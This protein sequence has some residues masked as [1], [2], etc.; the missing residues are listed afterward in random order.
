M[1]LQTVSFV[2]ISTIALSLSTSLNAQVQAQIGDVT[3]SRTTGQFFA[4]LDVK[5]K[6]LGDS[7][8]DAVSMRTVIKTA[9]DDTGRDLLD[10]E[11]TKGEFEKRNEQSRQ[12]CE[13]TLKLKN[14]ARKASSI[15][16]LTGEADLFVPGNDP[17]S[18]VKVDGFQKSGGQPVASPALSAAG[19]EITTYTKE[20]ADA[21]KAKKKEDAKKDS[22]ANLGAALS[23]AFGQMFT[24]GG[25]PNSITVHLKDPNDK[26]AGV[27][28][29]DE[30]GRKIEGNGWSSSGDKK[31]GETKTYNFQ[32]KL[33][34][35]ARLVV[36]IATEKSMV[37]VPFALKNVF[38]P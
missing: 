38:L 13:L 4:G 30:S 24:M 7:V 2:L 9:V 29:Q 10:R 3:D 34:D 21:A 22:K 16:E 17:N 1:K 6:L 37:V 31:T 12:N 11:K 26:V 19:I 15:K 14:P 33:P 27:E 20:Q 25:G 23:D 5:I 36:Y 28:F 8:G 32:S 18:I 35:T